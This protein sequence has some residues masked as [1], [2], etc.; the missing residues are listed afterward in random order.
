[1]ILDSKFVSAIVGVSMA[2]M[3]FESVPL[4]ADVI[5]DRR[6]EQFPTEPAHLFV[7]L[8]YSLPGIGSGFFLLGNFSNVFES[9]AD[10]SANVI[11]GDVEGYFVQLTEV[12]L[13][14]ETLLLDVFA[15]EITKLALNSYEKR[16]MDSKKDEFNILE[17]GSAQF[18]GPALTL[19]FF[20][21]RLDLIAGTQMQSVETIALRD[22]KGK[23]IAELDDPVVNETESTYYAIQID[24]TDDFQD[25]RAG[26]RLRLQTTNTPAADENE[27]E[28]DVTNYNTTI[29]FPVGE[30]STLAFNYYQSDANVTR[31][32]NTDRNAIE[33][34]LGIVCTSGDTVCEK[35]LEEQIDNT[36]A[37]RKNGTA[38]S[39]GG[40]DRLR[41][42][43]VN[44]FQGAHTAFYGVELRWNLTDELTP[45][46]YLFWKDVRT[47]IQI[48]FFGESGTVAE[49]SSELWDESRESYGMGLR[50]ITGSGQVY[51]A[52]FATGD[53][54]NEVTVFFFYPWQEAF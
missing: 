29:Y 7:P 27:A 51:R 50:L 23:L 52:D 42:Y 24:L 21:R 6:K 37:A 11:L 47:G 10:A 13:I 19:T 4:H 12:P 43:P 15:G 39:L 9:T 30:I 44:R 34:E 18:S 32:G 22:S 25:P 38:A 41:S 2:I 35:A 26:L 31:E 16:G 20:D 5:P 49:T 8:P 36:V 28:F 53:E 33:A 54:G 1:M 14:S 46:D 45:F 17:L 48:A 40:L 3:V